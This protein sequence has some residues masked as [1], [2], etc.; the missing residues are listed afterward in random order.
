[1]DT[2]TFTMF[3]RQMQSTQMVYG[4]EETSIIFIWRVR[5]FKDCL[6]EQK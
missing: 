3:S 4:T 6:Q 1:M 5:T 2:A